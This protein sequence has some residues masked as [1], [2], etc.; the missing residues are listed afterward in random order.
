MTLEILNLISLPIIEAV[1]DIECD[2]PPDLVFSTLEQ[3]ARDRFSDCY[4]VTRT[5]FLQEHQIGFKPNEQP[6]FS[7]RHTVQA[8]QFLQSDEKQLVQITTRGFSFNRLAP[9]TSLDDYLPEIERI[10]RIYMELA[11]PIRI[12]LVRLR[13]INRIELPAS[14][15]SVHLDDYFKIAP[16]FFED[17]KFTFAGFLNQHAALENETGNLVEIILTN[18]PL[19]GQILPIIFDTTVTDLTGGEPDEWPLIRT[20]ISELRTLK[21]RIFKNSLTDKCLDFYR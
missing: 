10:W 7:G 19:N 1:L 8:F 14:G 15:K 4:P 2:L 17:E 12:R 16:R 18:Q 13:Y 11:N 6:S 20:K 5:Q 9:Y 3:P 21:N